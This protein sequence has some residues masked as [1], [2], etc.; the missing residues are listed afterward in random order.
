MLWEKCLGQI[1]AGP[2]NRVLKFQLSDTWLGLL[3]TSCVPEGLGNIRKATLDCG[4]PRARGKREAPRQ[5]EA[6]C[7]EDRPGYGT[8]TWPLDPLVPGQPALLVREYN[9]VMN[10]I[11]WVFPHTTNQFSNSS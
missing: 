5:A 10:S 9:S 1:A 6:R 8:H 7:Q 2:G 4:S 11:M 3:A